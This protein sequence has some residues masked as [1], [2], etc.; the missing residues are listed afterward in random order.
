MAE[1]TKTLIYLLTALNNRTAFKYKGYEFRFD[2]ELKSIPV[3]VPSYIAEVL[4]QMKGR[5]S[6]CCK[7]RGGKPLFREV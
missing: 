1:K 2:S 4:L 5:N 3:E 6:P 7:G